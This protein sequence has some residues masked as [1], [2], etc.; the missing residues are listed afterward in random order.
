MK[1]LLLTT[2]LFLLTVTYSFCQETFYPYLTT[3]D[4][5]SVVI[6]TINQTRQ[7]NSVYDRLRFLEENSDSL[8]AALSVQKELL[9]RQLSVNKTLVSKNTELLI[10]LDD[11]KEKDVINTQ[12]KEYYLKE[13]NHQK[14]KGLKL[15]I[16]G[17]T[18][19]FTT[20]LL[21][22]LILD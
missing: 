21:M 20:G 17:V 11:W 10:E 22:V 15:A 9:T 2:I 12:L 6:I 1:Q 7:I 18:V 13:V 5:D 4:N 3:I 8:G 16:G 19:G 14:N